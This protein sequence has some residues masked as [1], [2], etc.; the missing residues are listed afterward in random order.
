MTLPLSGSSAFLIPFITAT[1]NFLPYPLS[2]SD[3]EQFPF[4]PV[5]LSL[6]SA[7]FW[8]GLIEFVTADAIV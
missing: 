2:R 6:A 1:G 3:L 8:K 5:L 7:R 4:Q